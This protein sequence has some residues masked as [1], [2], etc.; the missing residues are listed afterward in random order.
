MW[1]YQLAAYEKS[2]AF[3]HTEKSSYGKYIDYDEEEKK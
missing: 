2:I 3:Q 1:I